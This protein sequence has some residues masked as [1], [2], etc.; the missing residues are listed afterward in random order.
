[1]LDDAMVLPFALAEIE[2]GAATGV[3]DE[4]AMPRPCVF[5]HTNHLQ[6]LGARVARYALK[7]H[8]KHAEAFDVRIIHTGDYPFLR[9]R[10]GRLF[11]RDGIERPWRNNDLQSF[12]PLRFL[13]PELMGYR[14]R[15]IVIDPDIFAVTDVWELLNRDMH[16]A[17]IMCRRR[18]GVKRLRGHYASSV[19]LLDCSRLTH[20]R[21]EEQFG[22]MFEF[23]RDYMRWISLKLEP[24]GSIGLLENEW[25]DFDRLTERT[26]MVHNTRRITQ[27]WKTG[28]PVDFTPAE[29]CPLFP[30]FGWLMRWRRITFG[31]H[32]LLG[33]Y[34]RHPDRSQ[35]RLFFGL[36]H[37]CLEQGLVSEEEVRE[38][39]R[40][41]HVRHDAFE[42]ME[43]AAPLERLAA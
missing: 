1:M 38:E 41:N 16:G 35:E 18:T 15:A 25:N 20:W 5:I 37:E 21:C 30:P 7:R 11:L 26:K 42:V 29:T 6:Y 22:E 31:D 8:S 34:R 14:G 33:R 17:A 39:M 32:A 3:R 10:E 4:T 9:Q 28:L 24:R 36:L 43:R 19:M 27:P 40:S 12:T 2:A 13:P 23:K